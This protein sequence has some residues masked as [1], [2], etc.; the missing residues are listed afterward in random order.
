MHAIKARGTTLVAL[1]MA[2]VTFSKTGFISGN[3]SGFQNLPCCI[4]K[5]AYWTV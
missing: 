2:E 1:A 3:Y 5:C 4:C